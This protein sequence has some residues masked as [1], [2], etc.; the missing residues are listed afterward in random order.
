MNLH[1]ERPI[2]Y[3]AEA[4]AVRWYKRLSERQREDV[5]AWY[6]ENQDHA[7]EWRRSGV[8]FMTYPWLWFPTP[9]DSKHWRWYRFWEWLGFEPRNW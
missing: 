9:Q 3:E 4:Q 5:K 1:L 6:L 8:G 7:R 2:D